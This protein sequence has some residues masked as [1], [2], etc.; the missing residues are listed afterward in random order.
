[1][2]LSF[3]KNF[4]WVLF[5]TSL[6][7]VALG[8]SLI[9]STTLDFDSRTSLVKKQIISLGIGTILMFLI[10]LTHFQLFHTYAWVFYF[11]SIAILSSVLFFGEEIRGTRGWFFIGGFGIQVSEYAKI[12]LIISLARYFSS[13]KDRMYQ[14]R[15]I[16]ITGALMAVPTFLVLKEPD[17]GTALIFFSIWLCMLISSGVKRIHLL[18]LSALGVLGAIFSWLFVLAD[19]Q[20][21]RFFALLDPAS[22]PLDQGYNIIQSMVAVG[23]GGFLGKG[24]GH[25]TQSQLRFLPEQHTD[26]IFAVVAEELGF[27]GA[28]FLIGLLSFLFWKLITILKKTGDDFGVFVICGFLALLITETFV[29][30]GMNIGLLPII[31]IPLPLVSYGG[32]S[33][34]MTFVGLGILQSIKSH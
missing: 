33:L 1:M 18:I 10:S 23:S 2:I 9:Y 16:F 34:I 14:T 15:H 13:V 25:G 6:L 21:E 12:L 7:L 32:S 27:V 20:K 3:I 29:N 8:V 28:L 11:I 24:L 19:Y 30:I 17:S 31:G 26:F 4:D 22:D 5:I